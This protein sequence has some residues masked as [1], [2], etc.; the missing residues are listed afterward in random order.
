MPAL[1]LSFGWRTRSDIAGLAEIGAGAAGQLCFDLRAIVDGVDC[2]LDDEIGGMQPPEHL[3]HP[4]TLMPVVISTQ[5]ALL[6]TTLVTN[7][8]R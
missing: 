1:Y 3:G 6:P 8:R 5:V 4:S 7:W 2:V